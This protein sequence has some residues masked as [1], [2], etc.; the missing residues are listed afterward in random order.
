MNIISHSGKWENLESA[1][2]ANRAAHDYG[3]ARLTLA[4]TSVALTVALIRPGIWR[5][6]RHSDTVSV[7][8]DDDS[9]NRRRGIA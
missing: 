4:Q 3:S 9:K 7:K 2:K 5:I 6:Q 1:E 8:N